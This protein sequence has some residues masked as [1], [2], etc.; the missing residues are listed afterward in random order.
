M[1][2]PFVETAV[3]PGAIATAEALSV[4]NIDSPTE[5]GSIAGTVV[6]E[7]RLC[8]QTVA[9]ANE[10]TLYAWDSA[11]ST[12]ASSP[13]R[14]DGSSG[15]WIAV[16]GKYDNGARNFNSTL[17][18][19]GAATLSDALTV[20]GGTTNGG[21][22]VATTGPLTT[23]LASIG[24][25]STAP[26]WITGTGNTVLR[27]NATTS[28]GATATNRGINVKPTLV[29]GAYTCGLVSKAFLDLAT[30]NAGV[31]VTR[32]QGITVRADTTGATGNAG[33]VFGAQEAVT[34]TGNWCFYSDQATSS[35]HG[36]PWT[37]GDTTDSSSTTTGS[38]TVSGGVG[39]AKSVFIGA[40]LNVTSLVTATAGV[41]LGSGTTLANYVEGTFTPVIAGSTTAGTQ[42]YSV[43]VGRYTRIGNTVH[44]RLTVA[45]SALD[46]AA[47]GGTRITGL[48]F[49]ANSTSN[50]RNSAAIGLMANVTQ[51]AAKIA[52]T[53]HID[54]SATEVRMR[55]TASAA[56]TADLPVTNLG[57]T[58]QFSIAGSYEV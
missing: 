42:T 37:M 55:E 39:I 47:A 35:F 5:L 11:S 34:F 45:I 14:V 15:Q 6:G 3:G 40:A 46:G 1:T 36:G 52:F 20:A 4:A 26:A 43:Q 2:L 23:T 51:T 56:G 50:N 58:A 28:S 18:V 38:L 30:A 27:I 24:N 57:A 49:A 33:F 53:A 54:A 17:A 22:Y 19:I 16:A 9:A 29:A 10:W 25:T 32:T 21:V 12:G 13:Y 44:F 48:P 8:Y 7:K 31:T 41:R